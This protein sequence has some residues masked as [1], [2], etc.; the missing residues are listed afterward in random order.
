L[1][2]YYLL[3]NCINISECNEPQYP[4]LSIVTGT[5]TP[6]TVGQV[7]S[8]ECAN[9]NMLLTE[10]TVTCVEDDDY[11][12]SEGEEVSGETVPVCYIGKLEHQMLCIMAHVD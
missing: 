2:N 8:L 3:F 12:T 4:G 10:A 1:H 5:M 7:V 6:I 9:S 11:T